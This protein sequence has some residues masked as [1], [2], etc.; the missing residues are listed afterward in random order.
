MIIIAVIGVIVGCWLHGWQ[1]G[2]RNSQVEQLQKEKALLQA[3]IDRIQSIQNKAGKLDNEV[4]KATQGIKDGMLPDYTSAVLDCLRNQANGK[5][6]V[7]P[8]AITK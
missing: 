5:D 8:S 2:L 3:E 7:R 1:T 6:C 4:N